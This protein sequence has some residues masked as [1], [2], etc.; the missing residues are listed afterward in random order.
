MMR[1][2]RRDAYEWFLEASHLFRLHDKPQEAERMV[3]ALLRDY[4]DYD[5]AWALLGVLLTG[6]ENHEEK[7]E[8]LRRAVRLEPRIADYWDSLG[9]ALM[10]KGSFKESGEALEKAYQLDPTSV[11]LTLRRLE[12]TIS[13]PPVHPYFYYGASILLRI[14]GT[15]RE[16]EE[17]L[18]ASFENLV[19]V[20]LLLAGQ[21]EEAHRIAT[22]VVESDP[23]DSSGW[24]VIGSCLAKDEKW[25]EA[26]VAFKRALEIE[27]D[28]AYAWMGLAEALLNQERLD[29]AEEAKRKAEVFGY[30]IEPDT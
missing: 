10:Q 7:I 22:Q 24:Y 25:V 19:H 23:E 11:Q 12:N 4:P 6:E 29:E 21:N 1:K 18:L 28:Y 3:R 14:V 17:A 27:H 2:T 5:A 9:M 30:N 13:D 8:A 15:E 16:A 20:A 26:E